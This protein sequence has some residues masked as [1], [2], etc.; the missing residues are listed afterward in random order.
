MEKV[1]WHDSDDTGS[2]SHHEKP[3]ERSHS[4]SSAQPTALYNGAG[5]LGVTH[6]SPSDFKVNI[7]TKNSHQLNTSTYSQ[8]QSGGNRNQPSCLRTGWA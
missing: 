4:G 8:Q 2:T 6:S 1:Q 3:N 7:S 5:V